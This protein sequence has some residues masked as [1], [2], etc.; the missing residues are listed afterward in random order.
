MD[1]DSICLSVLTI[2]KLGGWGFLLAMRLRTQLLPKVFHQQAA[3]SGLMSQVKQL[4]HFQGVYEQAASRR[5][6]C[7]IFG[8]GRNWVLD[9]LCMAQLLH[10]HCRDVSTSQMCPFSPVCFWH[11]DLVGH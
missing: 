8:N 6:V 3:Q 11:A 5:E 10:K 7:Q 4:K 1:S 9:A 2:L